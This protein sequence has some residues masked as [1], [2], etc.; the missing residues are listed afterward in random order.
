VGANYSDEEGGLQTGVPPCQY[1]ALAECG[2]GPS[3]MYTFGLP[4]P[5]SPCLPGSG[6][7]ILCE[8]AGPEYARK[9]CRSFPGEGQNAFNSTFYN[10]DVMAPNYQLDIYI[11]GVDS[12]S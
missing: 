2:C 6:C 8:D 11:K 4:E 9:L 1:L 3:D 5:S 12:V 7:P 10:E